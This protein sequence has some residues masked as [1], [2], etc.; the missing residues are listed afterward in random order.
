MV[1]SDCAGGD[2]INIQSKTEDKGKHL[3][4]R[5]GIDV[6][7]SSRRNECSFALQFVGV[8]ANIM[9]ATSSGKT[10][11]FLY[12]L[13]RYPWL[14]QSTTSKNNRKTQGIP[15]GVNPPLTFTQW[16]QWRQVK[17]GVYGQVAWVREISLLMRPTQ[18]A[19][20]PTRWGRF[21]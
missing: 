4:D 21:L 7:C 10:S 5:V 2:A 9:D 6:P 8:K 1:A 20:V 14:G 12:P 18:T 11:F 15:G 3:F 17:L 16:K 13:V 19:R